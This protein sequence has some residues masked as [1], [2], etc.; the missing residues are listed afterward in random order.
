MI[1]VF[2]NALILAFPLCFFFASLGST[3][4]SMYSTNFKIGILKKIVGIV[5]LVVAINISYKFLL[6][7]LNTLMI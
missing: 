6:F 5:F 1:L 7:F 4:Y 3:Y 2:V